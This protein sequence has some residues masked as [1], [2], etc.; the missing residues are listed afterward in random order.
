MYSKCHT[1]YSH[2]ILRTCWSCFVIVKCFVSYVC[3]FLLNSVL[4]FGMIM[5]VFNC[6]RSVCSYNVE[7]L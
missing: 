3:M 1:R 2:S 5:Y 6:R 4:F 7:S